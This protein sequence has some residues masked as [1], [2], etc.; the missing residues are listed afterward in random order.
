MEPT[1]HTPSESESM[2]VRKTLGIVGRVALQSLPYLGVAL[3][4]S[5]GA[6]PA[7]AGVAGAGALPGIAAGSPALE[8]SLQLAG[9][10]LAV[11]GLAW[12]ATH[13]VRRHDD[14]VGGL[15]GLGAG[16]V[17]AYG[18]TQAPAISGVFGGGAIF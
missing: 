16:A 11:G 2:N 7:M 14:W 3:M 6:H 8:G 15:S 5:A 9:G 12:S 17:G 1:D 10:S 13:F 18:A 4:A